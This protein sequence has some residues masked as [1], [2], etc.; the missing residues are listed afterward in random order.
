MQTA[1]LLPCAWFASL[2]PRNCLF[3]AVAG[4]AAREQHHISPTGLA[5]TARALGS[6]AH[7]LRCVCVPRRSQPRAVGPQRAH[8]LTCFPRDPG[9]HLPTTTTTAEPRPR[10]P[11]RPVQIPRGGGKAGHH[12]VER[13]GRAARPRKRRWGSFWARDACALCARAP[14]PPAPRRRDQSRARRLRAAA[15]SR[16][17]LAAAQGADP[18]PERAHVT[19]GRRP[20]KARV[21]GADGLAS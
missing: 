1:N 21:I 3:R 11:A 16:Q 4:S 15:G 19:A 10:D 9:A 20:Q 14:G 12:P 13:I 8:G 17:R 7:L 2:S 6:A 5:A 18:T